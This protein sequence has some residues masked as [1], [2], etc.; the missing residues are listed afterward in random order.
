MLFAA[1]SGLSSM[2]GSWIVAHAA[3]ETSAAGPSIP[4]SNAVVG[5][6]SASEPA[7]LQALRP[8]SYAR[9]WQQHGIGVKQRGD[10]SRHHHPVDE[11][12]QVA[13]RLQNPPLFSLAETNQFAFHM[14][15]ERGVLLD[16]GTVVVGNRG[17]D[18]LVYLDSAGSVIKRAG[19]EGQ[20]PGEF[21]FMWSIFGGNNRV[22]A[23]DFQQP[24]V[25]VYSHRGDY[26]INIPIESS[27][28]TDVVGV[29]RD[30]TIVI[31]PSPREDAAS[32]AY[33]LVDSSGKRFKEIA[34]PLRPP[35]VPVTSAR[36]TGAVSLRLDGP[37]LP[38]HFHATIGS[39]VYLI[40]GEGKVYGFGPDGV[41]RL[42]FEA[43]SG[44]NVT[45]AMHDAITRRLP[46]VNVA[47]AART[48]I[49]NVGSRLPAV[50]M[51]AFSDTSGRLWLR[52]AECL[53]NSNPRVWEVVDTSGVFRARVEV[54]VGQRVL[55]ARGNLVL[56]NRTDELGVEHVEL[57]RS[58]PF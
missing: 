49:G 8:H 36:G 56:V 15:V 50:W 13:W 41:Q 45:T 32:A 7:T 44:P 2:C 3:P 54:P 17:F 58:R 55:A 40:S 5:S 47:R 29:L 4:E 20:G 27:W 57:Y 28:K 46:E 9:A 34:R 6:H 42:I 51:D 43:R 53:S 11:S 33:L 48:R 30:G 25:A 10:E 24:R 37:C 1:F 26:I 16:D 22:Y 14:L 31:A 19:G 39:V 35:A 38:T 23:S 52:R 18:E 21:E 12:S